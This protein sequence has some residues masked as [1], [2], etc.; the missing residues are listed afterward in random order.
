MP[1]ENGNGEAFAIS[2]LDA[3]VR[4]TRAKPGHMQ[5]ARSERR[6]EAREIRWSLLAPMV[7]AFLDDV[8]PATPNLF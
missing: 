8:P 4:Y 2:S 7:S 1:Q 5:W 3:W 6:S